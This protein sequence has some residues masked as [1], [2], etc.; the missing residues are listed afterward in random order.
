MK[1]FAKFFAGVWDSLDVPLFRPRPYSM[2]VVEG[3]DGFGNRLYAIQIYSPNFQVWKW[4]AA[5]LKDMEGSWLDS[6]AGALMF[7]SRE[8]AQRQLE[9]I[10]REL[11]EACCSPDASAS[12]EVRQ[13]MDGMLCKV[14]WR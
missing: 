2:R 13:E 11:R 12:L 7:F 10:R 1:E 14:V 4:F 3:R 5:D 6:D 8:D 9:V